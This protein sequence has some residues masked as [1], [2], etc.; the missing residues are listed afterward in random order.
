[1]RA[2]RGRETAP[3]LLVRSMVHRL[4][5]QFRLHG[6]KLPKKPDLVLTRHRTVILVHG[7]F[8]GSHEAMAEYLHKEE[9]WVHR[10]D[11]LQRDYKAHEANRNSASDLLLKVSVRIVE[12]REAYQHFL[13]EAQDKL[14]IQVNRVMAPSRGDVQLEGDVSRLEKQS[15]EMSARARAAIVRHAHRVR[16]TNG[17]CSAHLVVA[18]GGD[19]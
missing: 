11:V 1:M 8:W 16:R 17:T 7:C 15:R 13:I 5:L 18:D 6:R 10:N 2:I 4:D 12:R 9:T 3:E 19:K 14:M